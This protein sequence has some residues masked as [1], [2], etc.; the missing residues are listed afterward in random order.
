MPITL[1]TQSTR[2][3]VLTREELVAIGMEEGMT[4]DAAEVDADVI[5]GSVEDDKPSG[6]RFDLI[7]RLLVPQEYM[8]S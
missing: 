3:C 2:R 4:R 1:A 5:L 7:V 6:V 8:E